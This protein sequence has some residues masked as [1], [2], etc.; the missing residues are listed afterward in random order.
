MDKTNNLISEEQFI[1]TLHSLYN[2]KD[3]VFKITVPLVDYVYL[4]PDSYKTIRNKY[5]NLILKF[6]P[7]LKV[8][9]FLDL[10]SEDEECTDSTGEEYAFNL[11]AMNSKDNKACAAFASINNLPVLEYLWR[12]GFNWNEQTLYAAVKAKNTKC[13]QFALE[14]KCPLTSVSKSQFIDFIIN[15][16]SPDMLSCFEDNY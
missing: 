13:L 4:C 12:K 15:F 16:G 7:L 10:V 2:E 1:Y 3:A 14:K 8:F 5:C 6:S 9:E 11:I